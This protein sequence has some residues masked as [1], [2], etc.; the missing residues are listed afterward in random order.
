MKLNKKICMRCSG[1]DEHMLSYY[2]WEK[3][4]NEGIVLCSANSSTPQYIYKK[5]VQINECKYR[6]EQEILT[7]EI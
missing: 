1:L 2:D 6:W 5:Y 7:Q 3:R 4:W